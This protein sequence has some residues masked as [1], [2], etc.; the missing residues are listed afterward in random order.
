MV[1][2]FLSSE[3]LLLLEIEKIKTKTKNDGMNSK[4][5]R[6]INDQHPFKYKI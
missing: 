3:N 1:F 4:G 5:K 6:K 2:A